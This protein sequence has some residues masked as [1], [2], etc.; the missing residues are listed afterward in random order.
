MTLITSNF[1]TTR[2]LIRLLLSYGEVALGTAG[3]V[4]AN[5]ADIRRLIFV[6]HGN[7]P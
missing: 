2:G 3:I 1:G 7:L 4:T 5:Q 6:C